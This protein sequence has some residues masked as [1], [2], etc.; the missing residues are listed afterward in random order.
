VQGHEDDYLLHA[1]GNNCPKFNASLE[2]AWP[3][4]EKQALTTY[5]DFLTRLGQLF[6]TG[7]SMG[8]MDA[9]SACDYLSWA[10][11]E[12]ID[13]QFNYMQADINS[14]DALTNSYYNYYLDVDESLGYLAANQFLKKLLDQLRTL[15]GHLSFK[16]TFFYKHFLQRTRDEEH[17]G[18][19]LDDQPRFYFYT[20]EQVYMRLLLSGLIGK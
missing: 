15:T 5:K 17:L 19:A 4:Y 6:E 18:S 12:D 8:I 14:C 3:A 9:L 16:E 11:Y 13:L 1:D 10:Y 20:T 2:A 7:S